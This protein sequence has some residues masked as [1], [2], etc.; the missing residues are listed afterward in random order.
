MLKD[1]LIDRFQLRAHSATQD[2]PIYALVVARKD[3]KLGPQ[4]RRSNVD[5]DKIAAEALAVRGGAPPEVPKGEHPPCSIGFSGAGQMS[6]R[7][8][9]LSQLLTFFSQVTQRPVVDRTGIEGSFDVDLMWRPNPVSSGAENPD[10]ASVDLG[11]PS[12]FTAVQEQ[13]GL[14]LESVNAP[15]TTLVVDN[16]ERP[17]EN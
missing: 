7:S 14:K 12:I 2:R 16:I 6:A 8:K 11:R 5:C 1:L 10:A 4:L 13:F 9:P 3:G 15:L 17:T